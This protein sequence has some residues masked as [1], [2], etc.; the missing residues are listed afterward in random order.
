MDIATARRAASG[1]V[2]AVVFLLSIFLNPLWFL[3]PLI[4]CFGTAVGTVE[5]FHMAQRR[6]DKA[7]RSF[8]VIMAVCLVLV[9][10]AQGLDQRSAMF[11][12]VTAAFLGSFTLTLIRRGITRFLAH[13]SITFLGCFYVGLPLAMAMAILNGP[14][15]HQ[16]GRF[17]LVFLILVTWSADIGAYFVGR[18]FG[19]HKLAPTLS[20][21]KS[22]EGFVG[23]IGSTLFVAVLLKLV[24]PQIDELFLWSEVLILGL[25]FSTI[26]VMGDLVESAI[27]REAGVKDSGPDLTGHGGMLDIIDSLLFTAPIFYLHMIYLHPLLHG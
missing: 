19:R 18:K 7:N 1:I 13:S 24:W 17:L 2:F 4:V 26:G 27:K 3:A 16:V 21:G 12:V 8:A 6:Y 15:Y 14:N 11:F 23:G 9:G 20:P 10:Y 5:F 25:L 22:I